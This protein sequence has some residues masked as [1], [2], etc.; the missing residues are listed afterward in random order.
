MAHSGSEEK[1][2]FWRDERFWRIA[3][4]VITLVVVVTVLWLLWDNASVSLQRQGRQF[5]FNFLRNEAGFN[6]GETVVPYNPN[7]RYY[8]AIVVGLINTLRL[9]LVGFVLTTSV[10]IIAGIASFS[11]N[12]LV[13]KL[14]QVYVEVIRNTPLL[15]QLFIWYFGVFYAL[16][17]SA[18]PN[19]PNSLFEA[20]FITNK[21][22]VVPW[23]PPTPLSWISTLLLV[24]AIVTMGLLWRW[25][26]QLMVEQGASGKPQLTALIVLG[27]VA[28]LLLTIG[29][30][31]QFPTVSET[32]DIEGGL[33][34][35][36]EYVAVLSALVF[37]TG[38]FIAEIVRAGIQSVSKGQW[39]AARALGIH[40]GLVMRLVVFPQALRVIIP[41][42]NSQY[43]N[44]AKNS[45]LALAIGYPDIYSTANTTFNQTG[46]PIEVFLIIMAIYLSINLIITVV[47]NQLNR[48]VQLKE[49]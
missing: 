44:L 25:R 13:R 11:E 20:A 23:P 10:G 2:P 24:A 5:N 39:E 4:Q 31:W 27:V 41:S 43:M 46:R 36:I 33:R 45:S 37:Y 3:L 9:I 32:G 16:A 6:I 14:S 15:L 7:D 1:I 26:T 12:W 35:S 19:R 49:R 8:W 28:L 40:S 48:A 22:I 38:A 47:M 18:Q 29:L 17:R 34:L 30:N 21:G 42:L